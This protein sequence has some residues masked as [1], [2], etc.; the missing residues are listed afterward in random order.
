MK[1]GDLAIMVVRRLR[2]AYKVFEKE[3]VTVKI[4]DTYSS[5]NKPCEV[6]ENAKATLSRHPYPYAKNYL[7][8]KL[9]SDP[10]AVVKDNVRYLSA[11]NIEVVREIPLE[12]LQKD[13]DFEHACIENKK[14]QQASQELF[15]TQMAE[16]QKEREKE[17]LNFSKK[18]K[19]GIIVAAMPL[20]FVIIF[21]FLLPLLLT[22]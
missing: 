10:V 1:K 6:Y 21:G 19:I 11:D 14:R 7:E 13:P 22:R 3:D 18:M 4:G 9:L 20:A 15:E 8:V 5:D 17:E 16:M 2:D 12:E